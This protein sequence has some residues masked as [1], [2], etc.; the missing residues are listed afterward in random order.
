MSGAW[1]LDFLIFKS[2]ISTYFWAFW[3]NIFSIKIVPFR[4]YR[5]MK[6]IL[7]WSKFLN[8]FIYYI[9]MLWEWI[10]VFS[11]HRI[12]NLA[13]SSS[14]TSLMLLINWNIGTWPWKFPNLLWVLYY[15]SV[16]ILAK[17]IPSIFY[18]VVRKLTM[19]AIGRSSRHTFSICE[20]HFVS[21][22]KSCSSSLKSTLSYFIVRLLTSNF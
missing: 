10:L 2:T 22:T 9:S 4:I 1:Y 15:W 8:Y 5:T 3:I 6:W 17:T 21:E 14:I 11:S 19:P 12:R 18:F 7:A 16:L 13:K 20:I